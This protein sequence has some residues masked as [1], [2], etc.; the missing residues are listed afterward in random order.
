M[1]ATLLMAAA[2]VAQQTQREYE[3]P[4]AAGA[5]QKL[6]AQFTGDWDVVKTFF[7]ANGTP[8]VTKGACKQYLAQDGKF[9]VSDFIFVNPDGTK[10]TGT[11]ISG[12]D[13]K[14]NRFTTVWYDSRQ[15]TMSIRQSDGRFDGKNVILWAT[16]LD[17]DRPGRKTV[18]RAHLEEDGRLLFHRHF[19][20]DDKGQER[21]MIE[22]R[23]TRK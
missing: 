6:L 4:N 1:T 19:A 20:I 9:L 16:P 13:S 7:P 23:M 5:G 14:T 22:L 21:M 17:P 10:S 18:T 3:P 15:T 12:F 8:R 11:G 2:V